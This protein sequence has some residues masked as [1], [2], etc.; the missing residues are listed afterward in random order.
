MTPQ[1][2]YTLATV[3]VIAGIIAYG[4]ILDWVLR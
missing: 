4:L 2:R 3:L 1:T